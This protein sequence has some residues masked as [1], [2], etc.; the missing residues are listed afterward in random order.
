MVDDM[1]L[2][3]MMMIVAAAVVVVV[4]VVVLDEHAE[5]A[6]GLEGRG[7]HQHRFACRV[8]PHDHGQA[9]EAVTLGTGTVHTH[10][11]TQNTKHKTHN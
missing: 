9:V 11:H 2:V 6:L 3:L 10:T 8:L 5:E 7:A 1:I 4:V